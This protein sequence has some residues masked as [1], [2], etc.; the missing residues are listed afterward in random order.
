MKLFVLSDD[1]RESDE[2]KVWGIFSSHDLAE[3]AAYEIMES[4]GWDGDTFSI[5]SMI[6]D[7]SELSN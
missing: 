3:K 1:G 5:D 2:A 4:L 7:K 6:L